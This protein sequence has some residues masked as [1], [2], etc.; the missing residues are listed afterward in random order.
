MAS[1]GGRGWAIGFRSG[2]R[3]RA[4]VQRRGAYA[5]GVRGAA[6]G[7]TRGRGAARVIA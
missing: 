4:R 5:T 3:Q 7:I 1:V 2:G 6:S